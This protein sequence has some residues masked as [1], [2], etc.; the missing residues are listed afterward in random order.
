MPCTPNYPTAFP[1]EC[2]AAGIV[3]LKTANVGAGIDAGYVVLG[4]GLGI[5]RSSVLVGAKPPLS[6]AERS[7]LQE[8]FDLLE[9]GFGATADVASQLLALWNDI[10]APQLRA[11]LT[12]LL[13]ALG[14]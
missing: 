9:E 3:A 1:T 4:Y 14:S 5:V 2:V 6:D 8:L 7:Q 13:N 11:I 12:M 10:L